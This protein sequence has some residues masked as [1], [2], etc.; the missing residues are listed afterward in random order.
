L[1]V[2]GTGRKDAFGHCISLSLET[3]A[4]EGGLGEGGGPGDGAAEEA[5]ASGTTKGQL[6]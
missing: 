5:L 6:S 4:S 1:C 2:I 3:S